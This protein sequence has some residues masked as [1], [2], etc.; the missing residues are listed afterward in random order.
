V[1]R[2]EKLFPEIITMVKVFSFCLYGPPNPQYY[3]IPMLQNISLIETYFPD[4]KVYLYIAPDVDP[5]FLRK[6]AIYSN[7]VIRPTGKL[8]SINM[9]ERFFAIDEPEVEIMMVR[10]ADSHVHWKDRWAINQFLSNTQYNSHIIRDNKEHTSKMM[11]GLWGM[12]KI[13]GLVIE[14][15]YK[16][17][18]E[19]PSDRGYGEDQ[20]FLTD[21][22]YPYLWKNALVHYSNNRKI[23]GENGVQFPFEYVNE[24]Y[25]GRCD[26]EN[27]VDFPQPPF[28]PEKPER[29]FKFINEKLIIKT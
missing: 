26:F 23:H 8:G 25:C 16:L 28:S 20:S 12:R 17:Y 27:F 1:Q 4:W 6:L 5:E 22:V 13:E 18:K 7:V 14:D 10:D 15:L 21:Y 24:L 2:S 11:G 29:R 9:F 3:P 19:S